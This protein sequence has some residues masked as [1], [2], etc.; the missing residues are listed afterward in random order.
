[1]TPCIYPAE[2][3][4][5]FIRNTAAFLPDYTEERGINFYVTLLKKARNSFLGGS[6]TSHH[7]GK[8]S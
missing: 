7:A 2:V 8:I 6:V 4:G 5:L 3:G 1:M